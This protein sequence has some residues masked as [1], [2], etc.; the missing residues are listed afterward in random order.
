MLKEVIK[1]SIIFIIMSY[2]SQSCLKYNPTDK[3]P[4][5]TDFSYPVVRVNTAGDPVK[6][7][8]TVKQ[9]DGEAAY[10]HQFVRDCY[11]Q[12]KSVASENAWTQ[13]VQ[14]SSFYEDILKGVAKDYWDEDNG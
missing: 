14:F 7:Y 1:L 5:Y 9:Y 8:K 2:A 12:F 4:D 6:Q 13:E 10:L 11:K 3:S